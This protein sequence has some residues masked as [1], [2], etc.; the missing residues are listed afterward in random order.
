MWPRADAD[1][2]DGQALGD[3]R[4]QRRWNALQHQRE[5]AGLGERV[6]LIDQPAGVLLALPLDPVAAHGMH[7]LGRQPDVAH[8]GD[9]AVHQR[10]GE[11]DHGTLHFDGVRPS[12]L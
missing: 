9:A 6:R 4:R 1:G 8:D 3:L 10:R 2:G 12:F 7:G 5:D 11:L